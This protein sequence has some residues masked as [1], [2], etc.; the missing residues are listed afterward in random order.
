MTKEPTVAV[1]DSNPPAP[2]AAAPGPTPGP[3]GTVPTPATAPAKAAPAPAPAKAATGTRPRG[4]RI[5]VADALVIQAQL[6]GSNKY[7]DVYVAGADAERAAELAVIYAEHLSK[8][9]G[10]KFVVRDD[11]DGQD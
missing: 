8:E 5:Q 9:H 10:V 4:V 7:V 11:V 6:P 2:H 3:G 1:A